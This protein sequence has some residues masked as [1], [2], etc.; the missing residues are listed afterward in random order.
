MS[1]RLA[2]ESEDECPSPKTPCLAEAQISDDDSSYDEFDSGDETTPPPPDVRPTGNLCWCGEEMSHDLRRH[3][4]VA[5]SADAARRCVNCHD[6]SKSRALV[7]PTTLRNGPHGSKCSCCKR[8]CIPVFSSDDDF[9][10]TCMACS[11]DLDEMKC[12]NCGAHL[13]FRLRPKAKTYFEPDC[14]CGECVASA[15]VLSHCKHL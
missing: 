15:R 14:F 2:S 10:Y 11:T 13:G 6:E 3:N 8:K 12:A 5:R 1:K 4:Y 7:D 9:T